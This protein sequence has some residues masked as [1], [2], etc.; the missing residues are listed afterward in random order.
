MK[1][2]NNTKT[3]Q[4][5]FPEFTDDWQICKLKDIADIFDGTHQTPQYTDSGVKFVSV[6]NIANLETKKFIS[7]EAYTKEYANKQAEKGDILMTRIGDIGTTKVIET[8]EPL[9]YYVT[10]ALLKPKDIISS[11]LAYAISSPKVQDDIYK[12]TLQV[13]F[14]KKINLGEI[15]KIEIPIPSLPEQKKIGEFFH[16]LDNLI[17]AQNKKL[18][19]LKQLKKGYL[20]KMFPSD[21][22]TV[23]QIRFPEFT[24]PW[25]KRKLGRFGKAT[26]GTSIESY[27]NASGK[28]KVISIGS[29]SEQSVYTD[30]NI[31]IDLNKKIK[32]RVLNKGDLTM[33][34]N[35]K[36]S[37]G[38][39]IGRVLLIDEDDAYVYNQRTQR[40]EPNHNEYESQFLYQL[41][42]APNIRSKIIKQAQG[43]TQIYVNWSAISELD[44]FVPHTLAEQKKIGEFFQNLDNLIST[45]SDKIEAL[46][47]HKKGILQKMFV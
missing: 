43:N 3:P 4:I 40:I 27:F 7:K 31:R 2:I 18:D 6:E 19:N 35:D 20:Q 15:N 28:Y 47:Q 11:F 17:T 42:N 1:I 24:D 46:R 45:Q 9:A 13:A 8:K 14:P 36:T 21:G 29:Y 5:R 32:S 16:N 25:V 30:Q 33:I 23:P 38:N 22:K 41:L 26:G 10:L 34:L 12:R 39:I 37:S 44:Y